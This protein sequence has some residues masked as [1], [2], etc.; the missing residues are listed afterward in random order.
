M[1][2]VF[3]QQANRDSIGI[4]GIFDQSSTQSIFHRPGEPSTYEAHGRIYR[5]SCLGCLSPG[6]MRFAPDELKL[7]NDRLNEFPADVDDS[8]CPLNA[9]IW[10]RG[11]R[12]PSIVEER[13]INCGICARRCLMGAIY[14]NGETAVIHSGEPEVVF[15]S[16]SHENFKTHN[17]QLETLSVSIHA[18]RFVVP[19]E[20]AIANLYTRLSVQP[21]EAQFP[22]LIVRNL[23]LVHGN[24]CIIRRRGDVYF[25]IDSIV[26]DPTT[27]GII[28]IEF[29]KDSLESPRA[30]LDDIAV[31]S[32]RYGIRK[33]E[34]KPFIV[35]LEFP[36]VRTEYWRVLKDIKDVLGIRIHS[37]SLG[38]LCL[39]AWSF[40]KIPIGA[41]DFYAD[42]HKPSIR[43]DIERLSCIDQ[44]PILHSYAILE[45]K[46]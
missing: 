13:C 14:S 23:F 25:R 8:V 40:K 37:L 16:L 29:Q 11:E 27:I 3:K 6:C 38:A 17:I 34:L 46:K 32:S 42:I 30:I 1:S 4:N 43:A 31:L 44:L 18:G 15:S 12:T 28:E 35:S 41:M 7:F 10:E 22:N 36:N 45:S 21:T 39:L 19:S 26:A 5:A 33:E 20:T 24:Q 9:I 2:K